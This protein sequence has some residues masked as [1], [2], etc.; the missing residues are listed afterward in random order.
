MIYFW[1]KKES[2]QNLHNFLYIV[3]CNLIIIAVTYSVPNILIDIHFFPYSSKWN[4]ATYWSFLIH[5]T[6]Q[7]F[8]W[9]RRLW[10]PPP[11]LKELKTS[12]KSIWLKH[13]SNKQT[14]KWQKYYLPFEKHL[15]KVPPEWEGGCLLVCVG[16]FAGFFSFFPPPFCIL[17]PFLL[18]GGVPCLMLGIHLLTRLLK[19]AH[20]PVLR[21]KTTSDKTQFSK[22]LS[23]APNLKDHCS[24]RGKLDMLTSLAE[25]GPNYGVE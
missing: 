14:G 22:D 24:F 12:R 20:A 17:W 21:L 6:P 16:F 7:L 18:V 5:K 10:K 13:K 25:L 19:T 8:H 3:W 23:S 11:D 2:K 9:T 15:H 4:F 1:E